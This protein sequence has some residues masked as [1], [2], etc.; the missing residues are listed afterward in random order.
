MPRDNNHINRTSIVAECCRSAMIHSS[1]PLVRL[2][3]G[4]MFPRA[5]AAV[6]K[7]GRQ[8]QLPM[9]RHYATGTA[10]PLVSATQLQTAI[11]STPPPVVLDC[12]WFMPNVPRNAL[13]EFQKARIPG[14]R[15]FDLDTVTDKSSPYPHMLPTSSDFAQAVGSCLLFTF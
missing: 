6:W 4:S 3:T 13:A 15:F 9:Y 1:V 8:H 11:K 10:G 14:A 5:S 7:C 12:T 2:S